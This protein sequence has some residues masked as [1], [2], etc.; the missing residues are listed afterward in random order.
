MI[1]EGAFVLA[2]GLSIMAYIGLEMY[3]GYK[4]AVNENE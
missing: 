1:N 3:R 4:E 2:L